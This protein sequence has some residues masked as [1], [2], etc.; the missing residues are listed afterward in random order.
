MSCRLDSNSS[1]TITHCIKLVKAKLFNGRDLGMLSILMPFP[2]KLKCLQF[3]LSH[4]VNKGFSQRKG[5]TD[6]KGSRTRIWGE[7]TVIYVSR[8]LVSNSLLCYGLWPSRILL[9]H[10]PVEGSLGSLHLLAIYSMTT[11]VDFTK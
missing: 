9:I 11:Y 6:N 8:S 10:S 4:F 3:L 2:R 5:E 1:F 7:R